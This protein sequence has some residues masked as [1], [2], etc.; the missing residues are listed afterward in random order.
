[1]SPAFEETNT[2]LSSGELPVRLE[3]RVRFEDETEGMTVERRTVDNRTVWVAYPGK[4]GLADFMANQAVSQAVTLLAFFQSP[5]DPCLE[6][7]RFLS[8]SDGSVLRTDAGG[9]INLLVLQGEVIRAGSFNGFSTSVWELMRV[10]GGYQLEAK[11]EAGEACLVV[12]RWQVEV[13]QDEVYLWMIKAEGPSA[14][15]A[16][17]LAGEAVVPYLEE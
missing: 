16:G 1:M 8:G 13:D 3:D 17:R 6:P 10:G 7:G 15:S 14:I 11:R 2:R 4:D 9:R 12:S 5:P